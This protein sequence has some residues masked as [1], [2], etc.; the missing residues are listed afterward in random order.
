MGTRTVREGHAPGCLLLMMLCMVCARARGRLHL[1]PHPHTLQPL[2]QASLAQA[3]PQR[4][5]HGAL[6]GK[7]KQP[8]I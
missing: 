1:H 2:Q 3:A 7:R 5:A 8:G 4:T 6:Q